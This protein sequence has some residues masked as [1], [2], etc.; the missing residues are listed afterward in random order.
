MK[1][2]CD[3]SLIRICYQFEDCSPI[4]I[5]LPT[6]VT[7]NTAEYLSVLEGLGAA[8]RLNRKDIDVYMDSELVVNQVNTLLGRELRMGKQYQIKK[9][10]LL[11]LAQEV[12]RLV[13][14]FN[15]ITFTWL[16][17]ESNLAGFALEKTK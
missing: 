5:D 16:P 13:L 14:K 12:H 17:R 9:P 10:H 4:I 8:L 2:Y 1:L 6:P 15:Y 11:K 7:N 3:G